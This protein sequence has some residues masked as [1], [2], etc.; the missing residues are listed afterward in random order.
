MASVLHAIGAPQP[1]IE[2]QLIHQSDGAVDSYVVLYSDAEKQ[3]LTD[4]FGPAVLA[5]R[6][7]ILF[8]LRTTLP[9]C[10]PL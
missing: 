10:N 3:D 4:I 1:L 6:L 9:S 8:C 5:L 2:R 7:T